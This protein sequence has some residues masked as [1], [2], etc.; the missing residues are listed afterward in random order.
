MIIVNYEY[1]PKNQLNKRAGTFDYFLKGKQF[2]TLYVIEDILDYKESL[3]QERKR[4][5][6][7]L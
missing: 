5:K 2:G 7:Y 1:E 3:W 6:M 4:N